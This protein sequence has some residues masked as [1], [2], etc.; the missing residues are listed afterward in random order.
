M[1]CKTNLLPWFILHHQARQLLSE[2]REIAESGKDRRSMRK[3]YSSDEMARARRVVNKHQ[4]LRNILDV[5]RTLGFPGES[6]HTLPYDDTK[7]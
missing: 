7:Q 4:P 1:T 6:N 3:P 2:V 5:D